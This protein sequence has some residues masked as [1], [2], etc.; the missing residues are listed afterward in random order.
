MTT[1]G[2][3]TREPDAGTRPR[4]QRPLDELDRRLLGLLRD[5][6]RAPLVEL[7]RELGY[8]NATIHERVR[9]LERLGYIRSYHAEVDY[10][11]LGLDL[12][13][14]VGLQTPQSAEVRERLA[15]S[16][17]RM[18]EVV[19]MAWVTGDFDALVTVR[20]SGTTHLQQVVFRM[21]QAGGGAGTVRARTI[22]VMS[23]PFSKPGPDFEAIAASDM[24][25]QLGG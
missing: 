4:T 3:G 8:G 2:A 9:R 23:E 1:S 19:G 18:P 22:V 17:R 6:A 15:Q 20:V 14:Y 12:A 5:N 25:Q 24:G 11:R 21:I 7:A 16:L 10:S 13:A